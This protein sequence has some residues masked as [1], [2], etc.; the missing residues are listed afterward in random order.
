MP[1]NLVQDPSGA[2]VLQETATGG[3]TSEFIIRFADGREIAFGPGTTDADQT[4]IRVA[5]ETGATRYID[6]TGTTVAASATR[7]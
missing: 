3:S 5:N 2:T 1:F 7:P 4:Y 6:V